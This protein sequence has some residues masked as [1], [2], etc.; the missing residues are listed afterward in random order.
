M[1]Q[2]DNRTPEEPTK[3]TCVN[4]S[5]PIT[6]SAPASSQ[7]FFGIA[8]AVGLAIT[9]RS[10]RPAIIL[11]LSV[12]FLAGSSTRVVRPNDLLGPVFFRPLV[13][14]AVAIVLFDGGLDLVRRQMGHEDRDDVPRLR[15]I[16][17]LKRRR[18]V[19]A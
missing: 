15:G 9:S 18:D 7:I 8:L 11:L 6:S 4:Q 10:S 1:M 14:I 13:G 3:G 2:S 19:F 12:G 17:L 16:R 5:C